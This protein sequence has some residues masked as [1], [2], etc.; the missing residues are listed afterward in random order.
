[1][2]LFPDFGAETPAPRS[3]GLFAHDFDAPAPGGVILLDEEEAP[4]PPPPPITAD[5]LAAACAAAHHAGR[6]EGLASA[7]AAREAERRALL[8]TL[9]AQLGDAEAQIR[10][11]V[12]EAGGALSRLVLAA[13]Q[14]GFPAL[15][16]RHGA[17]EIARFT[18][19][20]TALLAA[21]PRIVIRVHPAMVPAA[22]AVLAEL[23]PE[24]R[25]AVLL[26]A[27]ETLPPGDARIAWQHGLAVRDTA[28]LRARIAEVLAPLGL[29]PD[30]APDTSLAAQPAQA[31]QSALH[32]AA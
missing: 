2:A 1:M 19:E 8:A 32:H 30:A 7:E 16:A 17:A 14:A 29:A 28:R 4:P 23:E 3:G 10:A 27:R 13:L 12:D 5:D 24:R 20:V 6:T 11:A 31:A 21:E 25:A 15:G 22:E 18:A 9:S 26:E